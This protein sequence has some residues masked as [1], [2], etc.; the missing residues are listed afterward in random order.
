MA[1]QFIQMAVFSGTYSKAGNSKLGRVGVIN[2]QAG[3]TCPGASDECAA[4]CYAKKGFYLMYGHQKRYG[5]STLQLPAK[6][7]KFVRIHASG[8]FDSVEYIEFWIET[9][10]AH[11]DTRFWAYTRSWNIPELLPALET[12][13]AVPNVQLFGSTDTSMP[14]PPEGW[15]VAYLETDNRFRGMECLEQNGKM[16]NCKECGYCFKKEK[17]NVKFNLH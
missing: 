11:P 6:L 8:D 14:E 12:L 9:A 16:P 10:I 7:P 2:R 17:G 5:E 3:S 1:N 4:F 13:R 15:R